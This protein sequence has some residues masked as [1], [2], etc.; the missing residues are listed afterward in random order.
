M[1]W[2]MIAAALLAAELP[3]RDARS[4]RPASRLDAPRTEAPAAPGQTVDTDELKLEDR[5]RGMNNG[6][7]GDAS[8]YQSQMP[9]T[10]AGID[11][12]TGRQPE[13]EINGLRYGT[14]VDDAQR[15][16]PRAR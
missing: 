1:K 13:R 4:P 11:P 14:S 9:V 8:G 16:G 2:M 6:R 15:L 12:N 3:G 7:S 10:G 5:A